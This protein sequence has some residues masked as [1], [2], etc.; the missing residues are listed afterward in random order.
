MTDYGIHFG[1]DEDEYHS[2]PCM[3]ASGI[4][5]ILIS[6]KDF[7]DESWMNPDKPVQEKKACLDFGKAVHSFVLEPETIG[8]YAPE[9]KGNEDSLKTVADMKEW[10]DSNAIAYK[11]SDA[12]PK[13]TSTILAADP[14]AP[15]FERQQV[16]YNLK[17]SDKTLLPP[18]DF[19]KLS[20]MEKLISQEKDFLQ[21][22]EGG[23][24]EVSFFVKCPFTGIKIKSRFDYLSLHMS[25]LKTFSRKSRAPLKILAKNEFLYNRYD[26]QWFTYMMARDE[27][28]KSIK[29]GQSQVFGD[30]NREWVDYLIDNSNDRFAFGFIE[31]SRP[32]NTFKLEMEKWRVP[33]EE[34]NMLYNHAQ[35]S[36]EKGVRKFVYYMDKYGPNTPWPEEDNYL[37]LTDKDVPLYFFEN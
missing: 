6:A 17:N 18:N 25:D 7:W 28:F 29:N 12:K 32:Y 14:D 20:L 27:A 10:L 8:K 9:F 2:V 1:L 16:A 37:K 33:G 3:S 36:Y 34:T 11:S 26:I 31:S 15:I 35:D 30:V 13:L 4:K 24:S 22:F 23:V 21:Y 19:D 5:K